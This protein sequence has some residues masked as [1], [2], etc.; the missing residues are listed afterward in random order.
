MSYTRRK[1][2]LY[3]WRTESGI[4]VDFLI[5]KRIAIEVKAT[6]RVQSEDNKGLKALRDEAAAQHYLLVSQ[7]P[8]ERLVD[9]I[10]C[11]PWQTFLTRLWQG[12]WL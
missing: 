3:F 8:V 9:G 5:E 6:R 7:D 12:A 10:E 4:E 1:E 11:L 2:T